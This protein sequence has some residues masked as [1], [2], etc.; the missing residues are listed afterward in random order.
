MSVDP[1]R[2][3]SDLMSTDPGRTAP[4]TMPFAARHIGVFDPADQDTMLKTLGLPSID[5][6][7]AAAVPASIRSTLALAL[8][9]ASSEAEVAAELRALAARNTV[10]ASMICRRY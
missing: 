10:H 4:G 3:V 8:P 1:V 5:E 2:K 7:I 6:L 9:P